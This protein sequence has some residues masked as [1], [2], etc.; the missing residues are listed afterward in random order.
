MAVPQHGR[1]VGHAGSAVLFAAA[2]L[3]WLLNHPYQGIWHDARIYGLLAAH[4]LTPDALA[5]DLFFRFG[6]QGELSLF[7]PFYGALVGWLGL[8]QA[9]WWVVL[10]GGIAWVA[11]VM[12]LANRM[13]GTG[14][15]AGFAVL[16]AAVVTVSY[17]PN[18]ST[19][20]LTENYATARSWALPLGLGGI[21]AL[22]GGR[23]SWALSLSMASLLLHPLLGIWPV[24]LCLLVWMR[25]G[26]AVTLVMLVVIAAG[27]VGLLDIDMPYLRLMRGDWLVFARNE[28]PDILFRPAGARL[29][30]HGAVLA[31][32]LLAVRWGREHC[33][34]IYRRALLLGSGGLALALIASF[35]LPVEI[36]VQGQPWRV[37]WLLLPL[38]MLALLD[39]GQR[40]GRESSNGSL[41]LGAAGAVATMG[42]TWW[43]PA[44]YF[45]AAAAFLP[46]EA[47]RRLD[48]WAG[49][50]RKY[51]TI[52]LGLVWLS[53][54]PGL[55][56]DWDI[57]GH[58]MLQPWWT[59]A[60]WLHGLVAGGYW[61]IAVL[62]VVPAVWRRPL[63]SASWRMAAACVLLGPAL[64]VL[65]KWDRRVESRR[66][67]EMCYLE[68]H[69]PAHPFLR[70]IAVGETVFW[71]ERELTV[72][73][74]LNRASYYGKVQRTGAV[75]SRPKFD[76][77]SRRDALVAAGNEPWQ[78]CVDPALDWLVMGGEVPGASPRAVWRKVGLYACADFRAVPP[79][80][81]F[82]RRGSAQ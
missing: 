59:G 35:W 22:V 78:P 32:L 71:P 52:A 66:E 36:L 4:W 57:A 31:G 27:G 28:A 17:S 63:P 77:W 9:S 81:T 60:E 48:D 1:S 62:A 11:A 72:W 21:A 70:E 45:A 6:S 79:A 33:R 68:R 14:A 29:V 73:F 23:R 5:P 58:Q 2:V 40:L 15:A 16:L 37:G 12:L 26:I 82:P 44:L 69:C 49:G 61:H 64:L 53:I 46:V 13:L 34:L 42:P 8:D 3:L 20:V 41:L 10:T 55:V 19:F 74:T 80:S 56:A 47:W 18:A 67:E 76:E 43:L 25:T 38:A 54:L 39:V 24:A 30:E 7:T 50:R 65:S 75:F 51:L